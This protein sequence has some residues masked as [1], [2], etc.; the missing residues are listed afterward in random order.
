MKKYLSTEK[1]KACRF[2]SNHGRRAGHDSLNTLTD[3][4]WRII[5]DF[6]DDKCWMC[7][8]E[9]NDIYMDDNEATR[10]H[11]IPVRDGGNNV[12]G[13]IVA[14]CRSCN[15]KQ[16]PVFE[17]AGVPDYITAFMAIT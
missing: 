12:Y 13:N 15:C 17:I 5:K 2:R 3:A 16:M 10:E 9:M 14:L 7:G 8:E 6:Q 4:E 11:V 1:G